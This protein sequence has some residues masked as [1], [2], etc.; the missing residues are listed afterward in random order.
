M[1]NP[2]ASPGEPTPFSGQPQPPVPSGQP[3]PQPSGY[4]FPT[5]PYEPVRTHGSPVTK[6]YYGQAS[7]G[8]SDPQQS[9]P[10]LASWIVRVAATLLDGAIVL[11]LFIAVS[12]LAALIA[13]ASS[14]ASGIFGILGFFSVIAFYIMQLVQQGKTG[15]TIGKKAV[16]IRVLREVDG[17]PTGPLM[18]IGRYFAHILDSI[19][20]IGY[21]WPL[22]DA[23]KQTFADKIC[24]TVVVQD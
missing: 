17:Q 23:K 19:F 13:Y 21:L 9:R 14:S 7:D 24:N 6:P 1:T 18:A 12:L 15:A 5:Q 16:K 4:G 20:Y 10:P 3:Q 2:F 11:G 22:W 8:Y